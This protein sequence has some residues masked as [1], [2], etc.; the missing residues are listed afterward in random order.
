[1]REAGAREEEGKG[2]GKGIV[3]TSSP[4]TRRSREVF[5]FF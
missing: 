2:E 4:E 5:E 1:M 3:L